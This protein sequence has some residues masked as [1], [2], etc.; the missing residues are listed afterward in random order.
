[1]DE[2]CHAGIGHHYSKTE[3]TDAP[4]HFRAPVRSDERTS[5]HY[6]L[7][8]AHVGRLRP[9]WSDCWTMR[10]TNRAAQIIGLKRLAIR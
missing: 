7:P 9:S 1:M 8:A 3:K 4:T 2:R 5:V 10:G 6:G